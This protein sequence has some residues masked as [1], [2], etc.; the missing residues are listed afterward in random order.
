M[1]WLVKNGI[2]SQVWSYPS[3]N[4]LLNGS[5]GYFMPEYQRIYSAEELKKREEHMNEFRMITEDG[6]SLNE[7]FSRY[8]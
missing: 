3:I 7:D 5:G 2:E 6:K 1:P 4:G 8:F